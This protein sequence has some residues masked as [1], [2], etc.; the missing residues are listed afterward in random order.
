MPSALYRTGYSRTH[1]PT[2]GSNAL[3]IP[4]HTTQGS[5]RPRETR[6][7]ARR[8]PAARRAR[9]QALRTM[10]HVSFL[11]FTALLCFA[12]LG[13]GAR[14]SAGQKELEKVRAQIRQLQEENDTW[15]VQ[16]AVVT[17]GE[18]VRN[19]AVNK[20]GMVPLNEGQ[21]RVARMPATR[22][23]GYYLPAAQAASEQSG[24]LYA[25]GEFLRQIFT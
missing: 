10:L 16:L 15:A 17:D 1:Y 6:Q 18:L 13:R 9:A 21:V 3:D 2:A 11:V 24:F 8:R 5:R 25:L 4:Y 23:A 22:P 14:V 20:L 12:L 7:Q 19:Y